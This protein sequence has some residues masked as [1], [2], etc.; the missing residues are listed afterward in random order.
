MAVGQGP[1]LL[2]EASLCVCLDFSQQ[3]CSAKKLQ[4]D[5]PSVQALI[6][7]CIS[8]TNVSLAETDH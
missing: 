1:Q 8:L 4:E 2:T 6:K 3:S 7:T 5:N